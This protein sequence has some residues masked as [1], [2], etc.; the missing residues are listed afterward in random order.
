MAKQSVHIGV[1][2]CSGCHIGEAINT[3]PLVNL[4]VEYPE[5]RCCRQYK[6]LCGNETLV[7]ISREIREHGLDSV[8]IAA[9][10]PRH[11]RESL[12]F[13]GIYNERVSLREGVAWLMEPGHEDTQIAAEDY[14]RMGIART[15]ASGLPDPYLQEATSPD[16]LVLGGGITGIQTALDG[17]RAGYSVLLVEKADRLGG[18]LNDWY[19][20]IPVSGGSQTNLDYFLSEK[21]EE[22]D[23]SPLISVYKNT[24]VE[25]VSGEPGKFEV[26][27]NKNGEITESMAGS[28]ILANGWKPYDASKITGLGYGLHQNVITQAEMEAMAKAGHIHRPS[29]MEIPEN[30]LFVQCAGS[31]DEQHLSYCSNVC[32]LTSLKQSLY[33]RRKIPGSK[34]FIVYKDIRTP[35]RNEHFYKEVQEDHRIFMT[36]GEITGMEKQENGSLSIT[37]SDNLM[38]EPMN[39]RADLVVLATGMVPNQSED[40]H[41]LYRKG[42]GLPKRKDGFPDSH[43]ICFPY[44]TQRTGIY[45]AGAVRTPQGIQGCME[46]AGGAVVKAIQ[47]IESI[48]RGEAVHPRSG[49]LSYPDLFMQRCTDCKRCTEECPFGSYDETEK[50][51][52]LPNPARCRRCGICMGSCP[53]RIINFDDYSIHAVSSMIKAVPIPDEFEEKPRILAFVCENDA[54][55]AFDMAALHR[56]RILPWLRII[57]VRCIGSINKI[58][59]SDALSA[60]FDGILQIGC[61]PGDDYQCHFITG[62]ELMET[63]SE[64]IQETLQ[65]MMLEPERIETVFLEIDEYH[66][67]PGIIEGYMETIESIGPNPFKD[68]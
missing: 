52:P 50:G 58:W 48:K 17:A 18:R 43:F 6:H 19:D 49:D 42:E 8:V 63:R 3:D 22:L 38:G 51:T 33:I 54:Y 16:I 14:L 7:E 37:L 13:A 11:K 10:S 60:G 24:T 36:R 45:A 65:T 26:K 1:Y 46:D 57:P 23:A 31:R 25:S 9:C 67:L 28:I 15:R 35:G 20:I 5:V 47:C 56:H 68:M 66:K 55:P 53:E 59:L 4:A 30:I 39:I 62:S 21:L 34:V 12:N 32:C 44:E 61:K 2:I 64:N 40:L 41:L 27:L 29:D